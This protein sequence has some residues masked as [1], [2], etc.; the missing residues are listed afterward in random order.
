MLY[1]NFKNTTFTQSTYNCNAGVGFFIALILRYFYPSALNT[2]WY[3]YLLGIVVFSFPG[4]L[5]SYKQYKSG[6]SLERVELSSRPFRGF[7]WNKK[8][9][10]CGADSFIWRSANY[11]IKLYFFSNSLFDLDLIKYFI[12][13]K[14]SPNQDLFLDVSSW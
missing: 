6:Y 13:A 9:H 8:P 7:N 3:S 14:A 1:G 12:V 5:A 4:L 10:E 2:N 11:P